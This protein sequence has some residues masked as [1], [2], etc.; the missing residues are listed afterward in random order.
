MKSIGELITDD[1][2]SVYV[3]RVGRCCCGCSGKHTTNPKYRELR[4]E[5]RGYTVDEDECDLKTV[6]R[7]L[8]KFQKNLA[9]VEKCDD[10]C[11]SFDV[12][13]GENRY[14]EPT[15]TMYV[16]YLVPSPEALAENRRLRAER[17]AEQ[18][19]REIEKIQG[20]GI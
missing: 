13:R 1:I 6:K 4:G 3:G 18:A 14:R 5:T 2:Q 15:G 10:T 19:K 12:I 16:I 11:Y 20:A 8:K 17:K 7:V 9:N